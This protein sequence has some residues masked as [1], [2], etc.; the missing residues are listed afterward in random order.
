MMS[1]LQSLQCRIYL[2]FN[3]QYDEASSLHFS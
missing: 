2:I 3:F 1:R